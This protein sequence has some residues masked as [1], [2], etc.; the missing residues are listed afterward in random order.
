[1]E[2]DA[3]QESGL[4]PRQGGEGAQSPENRPEEQGKESAPSQ[5]LRKLYKEIRKWKDKYRQLQAQRAEMEGR[6]RQLQELKS[7]LEDAHLTGLLTEAAATQDAINPA[8]V[9][10]FL[11]E[12]V[13][14]GEEFR[15]E[16]VAADGEPADTGA[17]RPSTV[18]E[19]VAHFLSRYPYH[20]KAKLSGG[21]G[22]A[23]TPSALADT[24]KEQIRGAT[25]HKELERIISKKQPG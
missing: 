18:E 4:T 13:V 14:L 11:R 24:L 7:R 15:P 2:K 23:P 19:L 10:T 1:M 25:S 5:E 22:S 17:A 8:Q 6:E 12:Q 20:R 3:V 21:S 9:A 16:V